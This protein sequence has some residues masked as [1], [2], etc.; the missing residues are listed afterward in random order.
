MDR[1]DS[2]N[3]TRHIHNFSIDTY[4]PTYINNYHKRK[5]GG[6]RGHVESIFR[7]VPGSRQ[8]VLFMSSM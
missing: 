5:M 6:G 4:L 3:D 1:R 8:K 2:G 7:V